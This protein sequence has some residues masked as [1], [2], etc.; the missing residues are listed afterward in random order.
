MAWTSSLTNL[1]I[2]LAVSFGSVHVR[3][4]FASLPPHRSS[5]VAFALYLGSNET[6]PRLGCAQRSALM[7]SWRH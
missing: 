6:R 3:G 2:D 7:V 5:K 4:S 1:D